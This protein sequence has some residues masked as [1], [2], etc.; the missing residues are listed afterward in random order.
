MHA[1][2]PAGYDFKAGVSDIME[3][4]GHARIYHNVHDE[5]TTAWIVSYQACSDGHSQNSRPMTPPAGRASRRAA[6]HGITMASGE[7]QCDN[8][9]HILCDNVCMT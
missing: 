7:A 3:L 8:Y 4:N 2:N 6:S 1:I 9:M 5:W